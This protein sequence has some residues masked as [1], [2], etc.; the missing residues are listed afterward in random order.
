MADFDIQITGLKEL[1]RALQE[2]AWPASRRALR[3][4][5]RQGANI[6]RDE[7]RN[8]APVRTGNLKRSIRT[9]ERREENG[10]MR[11]AVEVRRRAFYGRFLEYGTSKMTAKPFIRPA[12]SEKAD[13]AVEHMRD[14]LAEAIEIE[15]Q[16]ARR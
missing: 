14:A 11:F 6:V 5:M 13:V 8:K 3:K 7:V 12:A 2:L 4:G 1:D 10:W 9:R 16:R 15:M